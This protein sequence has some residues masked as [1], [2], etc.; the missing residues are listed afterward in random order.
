MVEDL[1]TLYYCGNSKSQHKL[2]KWACN[3]H[4][5]HEFL[6]LVI[7]LKMFQC[8]H[9]YFVLFLLGTIEKSQNNYNLIKITITITANKRL[10]IIK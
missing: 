8:Q 7:S 2:Y 4:F 9:F 3:F 5:G 6:V 1:N 10:F